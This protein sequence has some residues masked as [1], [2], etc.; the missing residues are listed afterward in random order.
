MPKT[1]FIGRCL[2]ALAF[3][4]VVPLA[5]AQTAGAAQGPDAAAATLAGTAAAGAA[6]DRPD[7]LGTLLK[8][9]SSEHP[10]DSARL[11]PLPAADPNIDLWQ[12]IRRG[13]AMPDL[14][15]RAAA[16]STRWYAARPDYFGRMAA[17]GNLYLF[18]I[19]EEIERRGMPTELALLPFVESA[20]QPEALS[21]AQ[22]AGLWQFIPSTG[23]LYRLEQNLWRDERRDVLESTRAAL[24]YLQKLHDD[25]GD[26]HLALAA[27][28]CGEGCVGRAVDRARARK[29]ST[30][31]ADLQLPRE[32]L[33]YV[34]KLQA[35]KNIVRDPAA[36]DVQLPAIRNEP[37]FA[38][39]RKTRDIDVETAA[40]LAEM[41][42]DEFRALNPSFNRP[43]IPAFAGSPASQPNL[44]L[45]ADRAEVF[46]ANLAAFEATGQPLASWT[47]YTVQGTDT[48]EAIAAR[49]GVGADHLREAN[50]IPKR[51]KLAAG[52]TIL[53]PRDETMADDIAPEKRNAALSLLPERSS[54][55]IVVYR[56]RR[57]DTLA[58]VARR[59]GVSSDEIVEMNR[60]RSR[61][62]FAGQRL[63]LAVTPAAQP[64][65][66]TVASAQ[67]TAARRR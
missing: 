61:E 8:K 26:W 9:L 48:V 51:H 54:Q 15:T 32:T 35:I 39:L 52:S 43:L 37:Y 67:K 23:R 55:R 47:A 46:L 34:P 1:K 18:H 40:R 3:A 19:V 7:P 63:N 50:R 53:I 6:T 41:P 28:N 62:L 59:Y 11:Q 64:A 24:D 4:A 20:M 30:A 57:G 45:P 5:A 31:Y 25:F 44:L 10:A 60:L 56:V 21:S 17:R 38:V 12:R 65:P 2:L 42:L 36:Y 13:F 66:R 16:G 33:G 49:A 14:E 29:R 22:A 58:G 27:Y